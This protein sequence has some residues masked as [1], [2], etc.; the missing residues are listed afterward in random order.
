MIAGLTLVALEWLDGVVKFLVNLESFRVLIRL[1]AA[2]VKAFERFVVLVNIYRMLDE[3]RWT[4][5]RLS[6]RS[7][8]GE[9]R[10]ASGYFPL[11]HLMDMQVHL[12]R[13][14]VDFAAAGVEH[15]FRVET[16]DVGL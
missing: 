12:T 5:E 3:L 10:E 15:R 8:F 13:L 7:T 16:V 1:V 14:A 9:S 6:T 4:R 2:G 11:S